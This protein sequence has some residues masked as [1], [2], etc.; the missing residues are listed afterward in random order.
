MLPHDPDFVAHQMLPDYDPHIYTAVGSGFIT[1]EEGQQ[2]KDKT[3]PEHRQVYVATMRALGKTVNYASIY[4]A[5]AAKIALTAKISLEEAKQAHDGYWKVNWSVNAIADEQVVITCS[6]GKKW[7]INPIN[8]LLY[9]LRT[10]KDRFSTLCQGT[11][12]YLFDMWLVIILSKMKS[13]WGVATLT[14]QMH[15]ELVVVCRDNPS[16]IEELTKMLYDSII[17]V[18]NKFMM[19]RDLG[20]DVQVGYRYSDIH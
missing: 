19:R 16:V 9:S 17:E 1:E 12:S 20:C 7:L 5:G 3:L 10:D 6:R 13:R 2:Y 18:S 4:G 14:A 15:D 11:G 8:G